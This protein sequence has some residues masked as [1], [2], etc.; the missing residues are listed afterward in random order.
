MYFDPAH[1]VEVRGM[2]GPIGVWG[3]MFV[4]FLFGIS[5]GMSLL[6][7][8]IKKGWTKYQLKP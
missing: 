2:I 3:F 4:A 7:Y 6:K 5:T 8:G 1:R